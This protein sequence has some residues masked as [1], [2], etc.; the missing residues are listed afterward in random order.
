[1]LKHVFLY[2]TITVIFNT[3]FEIFTAKGLIGI[4][5]RKGFL[6]FSPHISLF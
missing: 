2:Q 3:K 1:M 5:E 6:E 4:V